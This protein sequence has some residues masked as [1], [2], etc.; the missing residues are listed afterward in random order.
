MSEQGN[1]AGRGVFTKVDITEESYIAAE[2]HS[3]TLRFYPST[4]NLITELEEEAEALEVVEYY[5]HGYGFTSRRLGD[6]EVF[7]DSS[8]IT[9]VNHGCNGTYNVGEKTDY[10]EF[11]AKLDEPADA[12]NGRSH[13]GTSVFNPVIDRQLFLAG[14]DVSIRDIKAGEEILDNYLV[15]VAPVGNTVFLVLV[16]LYSHVSCRPL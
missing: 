3:Q 7:V 11:S 5:M 9:F 8:I 13:T 15:R 12:L 10:D 6:S 14:G 16:N 4:Y 2:T 1:S